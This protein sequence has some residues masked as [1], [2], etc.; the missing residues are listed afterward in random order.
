MRWDE[1]SLLLAGFSG[2]PDSLA[3]AG[4]LARVASLM[5]L[6]VE[7]VHIDHGLRQSSRKEAERARQI[8]HDLDLPITIHRISQD[9]VASHA[10]VG[11]EE[12]AR[13]ERYRVFASEV[14]RRGAAA[15][16][17]AHHQSDQAETVLLHVLRGA[18]V[19]GAA[20]MAE[21]VTLDVPWWVDAK[22]GASIHLPVW[23][24]FLAESRDE[25]RGYSA[26]LGRS[27][28]EDPSNVDRSLRR[29]AIRHSVLPLLEQTA[30]GATAALARYA[31]HAADADS[32]LHD[33]ARSTLAPAWNTNGSLRIDLVQ[34]AP[35]AVV[36]TCIY[37]WF[38][39]QG[40]DPSAE[41][42]DAVVDLVG[43][44]HRGRRI[45]VGQGRCAIVDARNLVLVECAEQTARGEEP[46]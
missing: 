17:L 24:P 22:A 12:A 32:L 38:V 44:P 39:A 14:E 19:H 43:Q 27:P 33:L 31:Q 42:I 13:R 2:G 45:E 16:A 26:R 23:R 28:I 30:P 20:G 15:V 41:R 9:A 35:P 21:F 7:L 5:Q 40:L 11:R 29:N 8:A 34:R 25:V 6:R 36:R 18:G 4:A 46:S 3:L 1:S 37:M 10:G